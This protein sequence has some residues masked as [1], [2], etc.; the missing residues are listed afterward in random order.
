MKKLFVLVCLACMLCT[1]IPNACAEEV[2]QI[3]YAT[4]ERDCLK[5]HAIVPEGEKVYVRVTMYLEGNYYIRLYTGVQEDGSF[6][7]DVFAL[8][9]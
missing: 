3:E 8:H 2:Y 4:Y 1:C 6:E 5:G 9:H 7:I